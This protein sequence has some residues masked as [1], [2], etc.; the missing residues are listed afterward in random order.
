M[1]PKY[2]AAESLDPKFLPIILRGDYSLSSCCRTDACHGEIDSS[3]QSSFVS[4]S[5][6]DVHGSP[7]RIK[8]SI[9]TLGGQ[10]RLSA[11][12]FQQ[13]KIPS[14]EFHLTHQTLKS[15]FLRSI[16]KMSKM[17]AEQSPKSP[18]SD[19]TPSQKQDPLERRRLQN[20]LSQRN[21]R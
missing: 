4:V 8:A 11:A 5:L 10:C 20:R 17:R 1:D 3:R 7:A 18:S 6:V 15:S 12:C 9:M 19:E 14:R 13:L 2:H 16:Q 21:H